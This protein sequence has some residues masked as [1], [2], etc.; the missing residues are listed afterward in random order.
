MKWCSREDLTQTEISAVLNNDSPY[1]LEGGSMVTKSCSAGKVMTG[2]AAK[3]MPW[4]A[5]VTGCDVSLK[6]GEGCLGC[7]IGC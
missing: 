2:Y 3:L 4:D 1:V 6:Y 5:S 7:N